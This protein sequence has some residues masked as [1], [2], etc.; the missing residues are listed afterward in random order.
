M[1]GRM[2][3][4]HGKGAQQTGR[5]GAHAGRRGRASEAAAV[6]DR[7]PGIDVAISSLRYHENLY[8]MKTRSR[9]WKESGKGPFPP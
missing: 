7:V 1:R 6:A 9:A 3:R 4:H 8:T 5:A 2:E